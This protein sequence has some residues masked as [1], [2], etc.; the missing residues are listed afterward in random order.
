MAKAGTMRA[1]GRVVLVGLLVI[2]ESH[3]GWAQETREQFWPELDAYVRLSPA[4]RLFF[5]A[6][7]VRE[8]DQFQESQVG[9]HIEFGLAPI[10]RRPDRGL[11]DQDRLQFLRLRAGIRRTFSLSGDERELSETRVVV[12]A[13]PRAFLP[14][15]ILMAIRNRLDFRWIEDQGYSWRYRPRLWLEREFGVAGIALVPYGSLEAFWDSRYDA[16]SRSRYQFGMAVPITTWFVPEAYYSRQIDT[17]PERSY[18]NALG[19][20]TTFYF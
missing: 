2:V 6:A 5:L 15:H 18:T 12:E 4:T 8:A 11:Y 19:I 7:P 13:T 1:L 20:V 9:A 16:W 3:R 17:S 10:R 14:W